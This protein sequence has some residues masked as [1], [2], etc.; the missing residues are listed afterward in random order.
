MLNKYVRNVV[1]GVLITSATVLTTAP[2]LADVPA[3]PKSV[4]GCKLTSVV[5]EY[6][7]GGVTVTC[8][9]TC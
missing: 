6:G 8:N 7:S 5:V 2:A 1:F 4:S 9:Y 3:C